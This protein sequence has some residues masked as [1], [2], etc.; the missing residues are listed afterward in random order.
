MPKIEKLK[1]NNTYRYYVD[2][3]IYMVVLER[4]ELHQPTCIQNIVPGVN[5]KMLG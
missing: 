2:T 3:Y 5:D 1:Q 4:S